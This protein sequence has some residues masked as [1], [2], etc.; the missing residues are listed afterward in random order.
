MI[1]LAP[2]VLFM[3]PDANLTVSRNLAL[4]MKATGVRQKQLSAATGVGQSTISSLLRYEVTR[5]SPT[6]DTLTALADYWRIEPWMLAIPDLPIELMTNRRLPHLVSL[7]AG[8]S[9]RGREYVEGVAEREHEYATRD[10]TRL[11]G[12]RKAS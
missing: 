11:P 10:D 8:V 9:E 1:A 4:L 5:K 12:D 2:T 3:R 7:Y 6:L